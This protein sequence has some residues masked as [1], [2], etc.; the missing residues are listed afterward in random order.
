VNLVYEAMEAHG[1]AGYVEESVMTRIYRQ[2][3]VHSI[4]EGSGNVMCLDIL[5]AIHREPLSAM[6]LVAELEKSRG[7]NA[8][9]DR[10]IDEVKARL[11][12]PP[13]EAAA[14]R[15]AETIA[16]ALQGAPLVRT[17]PSFVSDAF[18]ATR[19]CDHP[20]LSCGATRAKIDV[21]A[22]IGRATPHE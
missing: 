15:L 4:W 21:D 7:A 9:L 1:G 6:E 8:L 14:R 17:T 20:G 5:R 18:C 3:R 12:E 13:D 22:F 19:L 2:S 16:L 11:V 10:A